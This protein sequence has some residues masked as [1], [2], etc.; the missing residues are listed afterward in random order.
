MNIDPGRL[1]PPVPLVSL[2]DRHDLQ[3]RCIV[4]FM[5]RKDRI[6]AGTMHPVTG[7]I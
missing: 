1:N 5:F 3:D 2:F 4:S 7:V 6:S